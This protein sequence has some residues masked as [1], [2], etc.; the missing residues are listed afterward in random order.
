M[1]TIKHEL[2]FVKQLKPMGY[3]TVRKMK[4]KLIACP[5][6]QG[7]RKI[8]ICSCIVII[9]ATKE[10]NEI[11]MA[12]HCCSTLFSAFHIKHIYIYNIHNIFI[13]YIYIIYIY[14]IYICIYIYICV[15]VYIYILL[16]CV[17]LFF[18]AKFYH[19]E[20]L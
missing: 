11:N 7:K 20:V 3:K 5:N 16:Y 18:G 1:C 4:K 10:M 2:D 14:Y 12:I 15:C 6:N 13:I 8:K 17:Y 9:R 19:T